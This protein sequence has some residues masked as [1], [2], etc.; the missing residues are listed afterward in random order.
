MIN[1][2]QLQELIDRI[3]I[4]ENIKEMYRVEGKRKKLNYYEGKVEGLYLAMGIV[5][6]DRSTA[7]GMTLKERQKKL[8]KKMEQKSKPTREE[9][10]DDQQGKV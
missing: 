6:Y 5:G 1:Q 10:Q 7:V 9:T 3:I 4:C 8:K 2:D